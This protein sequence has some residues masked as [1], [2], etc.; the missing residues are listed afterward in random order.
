MPTSDFTTIAS[1]GGLLPT[2]LLR[3]LADPAA[4]LPFRLPAD[5]GLPAGTRLNETIAG[6]WRRLLPLWR[7]FRSRLELVPATEPATGLTNELWTLPLLRELGF[8]PLPTSAAPQ[9][10]GRLFP[11][12]RFFGNTALHLVG[13]HVALDRRL[14]SGR[15]APHALL[16]EWLNCHSDGRWGLLCNGRTLRVLRS[17]RA[18]GRPAYLEIDLAALFDGELYADFSLV[19]LLC[20]ASRFSPSSREAG[21]PVIEAYAQLAAEQSTR[22]LSALRSGVAEALQLL[23]RGF[24]SH[25]ANHA[26]RAELRAGRLTPAELHRQLLRVI[27]RLIFVCV[28]EDRP[29]DGQ[30]LLH[31]PAADAAARQARERYRRYYSLARLRT[32]AGKLRGSRHGDLWQQWLLVAAALSGAPQLQR[33]Q[34]TIPLDGLRRA[35]NLPALGGGLWQPDATAALNDS[36]LRNSDFLAALR[37]LAFTRHHGRL[38][39]VDYRHLGAEELGSVY[40]GL[41]ALTPQ[42]SADGNDF[43]YA[44]FAGNQRKT[45]GSYYTPDSLVQALLDQTLEPLLDQRLVQVEHVTL[46]WNR[47]RAAA[48]RGGRA[49][50]NAAPASAP[51]GRDA[52]EREVRAALQ[53]TPQQPLPHWLSSLHADCLARGSE[54]PLDYAG[55]AEAMLLRFSIVD[56]SVG[57]GH[58]LVG[59]AHRLARRLAGVRALADG[60]AAASAAGYQRA[61]RD[62]IGSCLYGVDLNPMAAELCKVNLWLEALEPGKP[63]AFLDHHIQVGNAL[64]GVPLLSSAELVAQGLPDGAFEPL[65]GDERTRVSAFKKRNKLERGGQQQLFGFGA[66]PDVATLAARSAQLSAGSDSEL[67]AVQARAAAF[68]EL[69]QSDAYR[70]FS[71]LADLWCAAFVWPRGSSDA[72]APTG[73][74]LRQLWLSGS[75]ELP[76]EQAQTL[77]T[78]RRD[79]AF[80][81]WPIAFAHIF[82]RGGFDCVVGNPPW[83]RIKIQEKEWF[84]E[85]MPAIAAAG[86]AAERKRLIDAL[87]QQDALLAAQFAAALRRSSGEGQILRNSGRYPLCGR[88]DINLY[89]VFAELG[90]QLINPDGRLGLILPTGIAGDA[91]TQHF[92]NDIVQ[93]RSLVS[94]FDFQNNGFFSD[95]IQL[96]KFCLITV[97]NGTT[98]PQHSPEFV[99]F[100]RDV[101]E[102][103]HPERRL[104]LSQQDLE[105]LSPNTGSA[106]LFR[107]HADAEL[108]KAIYRRVPLLWRDGQDGLPDSNPWGLRWWLMYQMAGD[109]GLFRSAAQ[110][111]RDGWQPD[112]A[113]YRRGAERYV[114]LYEAKLAHH[115]DHRWAKYDNGKVRPFTAEE[116]RDPQQTATPRYWL[117]ERDMRQRLARVGWQREWLIG[118]RDIARST[119]ERTMIVS[120]L[121]TVGIGH[122][123]PLILAPAGHAPLLAMLSSFVVDYLT[124]QR[125]GGTHLTQNYLKQLPIL[126]PAVFMPDSGIPG[127]GGG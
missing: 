103:A 125:V 126:P 34:Q 118:M 28:A 62:V 122:V 17:S 38:R 112:G 89:A 72:D 105:L 39:P 98:Q 57:S 86:S 3:R 29:V 99:F 13:A 19:W 80:F 61:L 6:A 64:L 100:A 65:P 24:V 60:D 90:R 67:A 77:E 97:S 108:N 51:R 49:A 53:L 18:L 15:A 119:D 123:L 7:S 74:T 35:L 47:L 37:K 107:S 14:P 70:L 81:H 121:P 66:Q 32:L 45:S 71:R 88:G 68:A 12:V 27:Y 11:I 83:E 5:Y 30:P 109:S 76:A 41:L 84:A 114:P 22:A 94:L 26:L 31:P 104:T 16:Q 85:R 40:E 44:E 2:D 56:P 50:A 120:V 1:V 54:L 20:H 91:N 110:L 87:P 101:S 95:V 93:T 82:A 43:S 59:A 115:F 106:P 58:F 33:R 78:L 4:Q 116:K 42:I 96:M 92:F 69:Q 9:I 36:E 21:A 46:H 10:E 8:G 25:P 73:G 111:V 63:I 23:G 55:L 102:L 79:F 117:P 48:A 75:A 52:F 113:G 127:G 124:R